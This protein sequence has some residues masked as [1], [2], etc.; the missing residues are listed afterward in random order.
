ML[1]SRWRI[2][3]NKNTFNRQYV[4]WKYRETPYEI[5]G[6]D[7]HVQLQDI[8]SRY[9]QLSFDFHPDKNMHLNHLDREKR[10]E[11]F[12][13]IQEAYEILSDI[14]LRREYD[15]LKSMPS[16]H[17][18]SFHQNNY[19][20][21]KSYE[22]YQQGNSSYDGFQVIYPWFYGLAFV[23]ICSWFLNTRLADARERQKKLAWA[24]Y[25][26]EREKE[27]LLDIVGKDEYPTRK[28]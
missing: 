15:A 11:T 4:T 20:F 26:K 24:I 5:L 17:S 23:L 6:V 28:L 9:Y 12:I 22:K 3:V 10:Q 16:S 2:L 21:Y 13:K 19:S 27:G 7:S 1:C 25:L 14:T 18:T 8:K